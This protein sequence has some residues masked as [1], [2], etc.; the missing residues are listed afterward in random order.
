MLWNKRTNANVIIRNKSSFGVATVAPVTWLRA[1]SHHHVVDYFVITGCP[2]AFSTL[3]CLYGSLINTH[4]GQPSVLLI[5]LRILS[6]TQISFISRHVSLLF[7]LTPFFFFF[8]KTTSLA[9]CQ[10]IIAW[11]V[12]KS[13]FSFLV[14]FWLLMY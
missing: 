7:F 3:P 6:S 13:L 9:W 10:C 5:W 14:I 4:I 8:L 12:I 1:A 11:I 2:V